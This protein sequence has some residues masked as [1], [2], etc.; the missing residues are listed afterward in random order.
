LADIPGTPVLPAQ[1]R[2]KTWNRTRDCLW[3]IAAKKE[4]YGDPF[5]WRILYNANRQKLTRPGN[6][7]L[8]EPGMILDIP[9]INGEIRSGI[10][11]E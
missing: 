9:S 8:I 6:P 10:L 7:N 11:E 2:V 1:Y 4:I 3:N 5:K